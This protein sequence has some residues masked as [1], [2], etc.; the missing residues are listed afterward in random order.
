MK[1]A[2]KVSYYVGMT[3]SMFIGIWHFFVPW[4][5]G[6]KQYI[7][8]EYANLVVLIDWIN[9]L[10]SFFLSG[11]SILLIC[12]GR[13]VFDGNKE[14]ITVFGFMTV[15]WIFRVVIAVI[16]PYPVAVLAWAAYGQF[17]GS[18]VIMTMLIFA[19]V[20]VRTMAANKK[21]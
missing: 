6:W 8:S 19:F 20:Q 10:F 9:L 16:E 18:I 4:L 3:S 17:I 14:A 13:K 7:P 2:A 11:L 1:K 5:Y 21:R 15:V 12:W